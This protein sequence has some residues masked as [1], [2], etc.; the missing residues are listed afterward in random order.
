VPYPFAH[1]A[2]VLPLPRIMGRFAAPSA[3]AIGSIAPDLWYFAPLVHRQDSHS[4]G[5][6]FWFCLPAGLAAYLLFHLVFKQP[7]VALLSPRLASF[8]PPGLPREPWYAVMASLLVGAITHLVW[9][10]LTH[11]D[12]HRWLQHAST[13]AGTAILA[14]WSW[15][16]LRGA[17]A[18]AHAARLSPL[19][20][21]SVMVC[22]LCAMALAA[23]WSADHAISFDRAALRHLLRSAGI[24][25]LQGLGVALLIYC[26][27]FQRKMP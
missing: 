19:W 24:G 25:A 21:I 10:A 22:L 18:A 26:L 23:L 5:G 2:A 16:K 6:L 27:A 13:I 8:S 9:D 17:P 14:W 4:I 12:S 1:P 11:S 15:R 3:L 20:R 7:L